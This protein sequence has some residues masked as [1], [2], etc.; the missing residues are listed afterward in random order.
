MLD[1]HGSEL[2]TRNADSI[3]Y[4][5]AAA[6]VCAVGVRRWSPLGVTVVC[7]AALTAW[8]LMGH[9]GEM[10]NLPTMVGLYTIADVGA[11]R[12]SIVVAAVSMV[13]LGALA[14]TSDVAEDVRGGA[15]I[16]EMIWPLVP[17]AL[18]EA[19]RSRRDLM[20]EHAARADRAE[21]ER[22]RE[23]RIRVEEERMRIAREFHDVVAHTMT[24]VN[25]QI[26]VV[27]A[28][29]DVK[30]EAAKEALGLARASSRAAL[31]ELRAVVAV[32]RD[33]PDTPSRTPSPALA[34]LG[35]VIESARRG[36]LEI[37]LHDSSAAFPVSAAV[38]SAAYRV[39]QEALTNVIRHSDAQ[40][41]TVSL[42]HQGDDFVVDVTDDGR[43]KAADATNVDGAQE[44]RA[45]FGLIGMAERASALGG[46]VVHGEI[47]P[48]GF[49][50]R[51]VFP[52]AL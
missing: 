29:F 12:R 19:G 45:G 43:P 33:G 52:R 38:E 11:R 20:R 9:H 50:V 34:D 46:H 28:A 31:R 30:P 5:L 6:Q 15:P 41:V 26:E 21:A 16:F 36:G 27:A 37:V 47:S 4:A 48:A 22:E 35:G 23:A 7:G 44:P 3:S 42:R 10:L 51:A 8:Y 39:V 2:G 17:L 1:L 13:W 40:H 32:M 18:G 25:V 24:A 49:R 14:F